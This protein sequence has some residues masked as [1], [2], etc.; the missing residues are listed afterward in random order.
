MAK[1]EYMKIADASR[2]KQKRTRERKKKEESSKQRLE[3]IA[4]R[5]HKEDNRSIWSINKE[6][7]ERNARATRERWAEEKKA[8]EAAANAAQT[9][10]SAT[11][12][13]AVDNNHTPVHQAVDNTVHS[14]A[15]TVHPMASMEQEYQPSY[16]DDIFENEPEAV[17]ELSH[18]TAYEHDQQK[19][20]LQEAE[21]QRLEK[22]KNKKE[23]SLK[24]R[25]Q[26]AQ[27]HLDWWKEIEPAVSQSYQ[28]LISETGK[29][30]PG[31]FSDNFKQYNCNGCNPRCEVHLI[32]LSG[33]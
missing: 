21:N 28:S 19:K 1:P 2:P 27:D 31:S 16:D 14:M 20:V 12:Q 9:N 32:C 26:I 30:P 5:I 13:S 15:S 10:A 23:E 33:R 17:A 7:R 18:L 11:S 29:P 8:A 25:K 3:R 22:S 24:A 6:R 4:K